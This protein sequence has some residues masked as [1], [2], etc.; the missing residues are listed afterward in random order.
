MDNWVLRKT[1][2]DII[3]EKG[4]ME[5]QLLKSALGRKRAACSEDFFIY[6]LVVVHMCTA[7]YRILIVCCSQRIWPAQFCTKRFFR[8]RSLWLPPTGRPSLHNPL[9][10]GVE[11]SSLYAKQSC[12]AKPSLLG[13]NSSKQALLL[14]CW[15]VFLRI[16]GGMVLISFYVSIDHQHVFQFWSQPNLWGRERERLT[17]DGSLS[18]V[19][20]SPAMETEQPKKSILYSV[21]FGGAGCLEA[22]WRG[23]FVRWMTTPFQKSF[24]LH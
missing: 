24:L 20:W 17:L 16:A 12:A 11:K 1:E 22:D 23:L 5:E 14:F 13:T 3:D 2:T 8:G 7:H 6:R 19:F 21:A 18:E 10:G 15:I 4:S 9:L